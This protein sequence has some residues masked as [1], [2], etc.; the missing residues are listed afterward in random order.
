M[1][2]LWVVCVFVCDSGDR[3]EKFANIVPLTRK[4]NTA[5]ELRVRA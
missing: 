1:S 4:I 5:A 2:L 3:N